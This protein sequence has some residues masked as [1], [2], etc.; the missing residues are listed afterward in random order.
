M[1]FVFQRED[2]PET[3]RLG[4]AVTRKTGGAVQRNRVKRIVREFFRLHQVLLPARTDMVVVPKRGLHPSRLS[5][6]SA[7]KEFLPLLAAV[8][9]A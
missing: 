6:D 4:L 9:G 2:G 8:S 7:G 5:L 1:V 3:W